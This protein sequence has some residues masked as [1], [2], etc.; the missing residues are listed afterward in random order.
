MLV[1]AVNSSAGE[2]LY[3]GIQLPSQWPP[4]GKTFPSTERPPYL[5]RPPKVITIDAGRQLF[6]D[7]FLIEST[8]MTRTHH[9]PVYHPS[10]PVLKPERDYEMEGYGP[11]AAPYSGGVWFDP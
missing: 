10:N 4:D 3:N 7:D 5:E 2:T 1:F 8:D 11:F 6:F 9:R